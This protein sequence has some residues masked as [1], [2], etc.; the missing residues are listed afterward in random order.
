MPFGI[1][2]PEIVVI[3]VLALVLLGPK[4]LPEAGRSVGRGLREFKAALTTD[5]SVKRDE[6]E[7]STAASRAG[8]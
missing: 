2:G 6:D 5:S 7:D 8:G 1:S 4:R 3:L